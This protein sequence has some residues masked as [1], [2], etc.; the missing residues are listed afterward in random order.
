MQY[1]RFLL[2][3]M[4]HDIVDCRS[5]RMHELEVAISRQ[6]QLALDRGKFLL[7]S[8]LSA[9]T[10]TRRQIDSNE[11]NTR[12]WHA[13][14]SLFPELHRVHLECHEDWS[15][16]DVALVDL[17]RRQWPAIC[18]V[19]GHLL[20]RVNL[21]VQLRSLTRPS[22]S[23]D[24]PEPGGGRACAGG[25]RRPLALVGTTGA[26]SS[27]SHETRAGPGPTAARAC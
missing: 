2:R 4:P 14:T 23:V 12:L 7:Q 18:S 6:A 17:G 15:V 13:G 19:H 22:L 9:T 24:A 27:A 20:V 8:E 10:R 26:S 21:T 16:H 5:P 25:A 1:Q 11:Q 3:E